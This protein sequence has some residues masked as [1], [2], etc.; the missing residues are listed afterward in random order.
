MERLEAAKVRNAISQRT[1]S[2]DGGGD[3]GHRERRPLL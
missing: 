2:Y 3:A 1:L